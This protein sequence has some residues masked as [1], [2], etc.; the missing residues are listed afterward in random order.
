MKKYYLYIL[1]NKK[2]GTIYIGITN[3]LIKRVYN[4]KNFRPDDIIL[5]ISIQPKIFGNHGNIQ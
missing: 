4:H 5:N 2:N 1:A 3:D